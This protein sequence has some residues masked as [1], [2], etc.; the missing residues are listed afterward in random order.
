MYW[1]FIKLIWFEFPYNSLQLFKSSFLCEK[2]GRKE[3]NYGVDTS[4]QQRLTL[5][6][7]QS[8][9]DLS[10]TY[11]NPVLCTIKFPQAQNNNQVVTKAKSWCNIG[12]SPAFFSSSWFKLDIA[13][14]ILER[15]QGVTVV[16][17]KVLKQ[18]KQKSKLKA[19]SANLFSI[20]QSFCV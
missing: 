17:L 13:K 4:V 10:L 1:K 11:F 6:L 18:N 5:Q 7:G 14:M 19:V 15:S 12:C 20:K 2:E 3:G 16:W 9:F 8:G